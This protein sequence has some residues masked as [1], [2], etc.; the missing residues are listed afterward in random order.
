MS[1]I[2]NT[3]Y[4][5]LERI[6]GRRCIMTGD[7]LK[8]GFVKVKGYDIHYIE[9]R[10]TGRQIVVLHGTD[11]FDWAYG[12]HDLCNSLSDDFHILAFDLLGHGKSDDPSEPLGFVKHAEILRKAVKEKSF[13]EAILIGYSFGGWISMRYVATFPQDIDK[14]VILDAAPRIYPTPIARINAWESPIPPKHFK[15]EKEVLDYLFSIYPSAPKKY[16]R[17]QVKYFEKDGENR[18]LTPSHP[19]RWKNLRLDG[20]GWSF[21]RKIQIP[22]LLIRGSESSIA[23]SED[24]EK[25]RQTNKHLK[26][27]TIEGATHLVPISHLKEVI[28]AIRDFLKNHLKMGETLKTS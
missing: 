2:S 1:L 9:W 12:L 6:E 25:M 4:Y 13:R 15:N 3:F 23:N 27:V 16:L 14:L 7:N 21:F 10:R 11:A 18:V 20:D 22:I 28:R 8:E 5:F 17:D 19:T 26:I 24:A